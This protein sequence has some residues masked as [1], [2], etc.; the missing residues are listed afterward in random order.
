MSTPRPPT[1]ASVSALLK[2]AGF[3]RSN[4]DNRNLMTGY[5]AYGSWQR[6]VLDLDGPLLP[7]VIVTHAD[8]GQHDTEQAWERHLRKAEEMLSR[9]AE[10]IHA[11]GYDPDLK[12]GGNPRLVIAAAPELPAN[13]APAGEKE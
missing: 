1:P 6:N 10:I 5:H 2:Q 4:G 13:P 8:E 3:E 9:Y 7:C 12:R 11:G